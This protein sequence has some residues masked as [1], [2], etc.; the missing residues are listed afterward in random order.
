MDWYCSAV[1]G[2]QVAV[3]GAYVGIPPA[4]NSGGAPSSQSGYGK[5]NV[6][7]G[8]GPD[9]QLRAE[10]HPSLS[11]SRLAAQKSGGVDIFGRFDGC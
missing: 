5:Q 9:W 8:Q 11:S 2:G 7:F 10:A 4:V 3:V 1:V 6:P